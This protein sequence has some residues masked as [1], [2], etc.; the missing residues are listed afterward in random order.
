MRFKGLVFVGTLAMVGCGQA[1][2]SSAPASPQV[3]LQNPDTF[4][5]RDR[6]FGLTESVDGSIRAFVAQRGDATDIMIMRRTDSGWTDPAPLDF[7]RRETN[8]SAH[9]SPF[10]GRF[11][12]AS[13][14]AHPER[15]GRND[16]NIWSGILQDDNTLLDAKPMPN[17]IN[18]GA[19]EDSIAFTADGDMFFTS[20]HRR[21]AGGFDIYAAH[22]DESGVWQFEGLPN[23]TRMAD[24]QVVVTPDGQ[25]MFNYAHMPDVIGV[26]DIYR[27]DRTEEG[28]SEPVN[29]GPLINTDQIDYGPGLSADGERFFF[30]RQGQLME[31]ALDVVLAAPET[32]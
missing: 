27:R 21:G 1:N 28:W 12:F 30:S 18:T 14:A 3:I 10:D 32:E 23:N 11:Y 19:S 13:D 20:S 22:M 8:M 17:E 15:P 31:V 9:F 26:V 24:S 2:Q 25:H 16:L 29:L 5:P 6:N 7:P 4:S